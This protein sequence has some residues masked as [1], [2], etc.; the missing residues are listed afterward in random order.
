METS[1]VRRDVGKSV[2]DVVQ[3]DEE[4][5][6]SPDARRSRPNCL[7]VRHGWTKAR[8]KA[9]AA[10]KARNM[11]GGLSLMPT[12]TAAIAATPQIARNIKVR[13]RSWGVA[14][15]CSMIT[16][17]S[18]RRSRA[19]ATD[20]HYIRIESIFGSDS[21]RRIM[22]PALLGGDIR[23]YGA[24]AKEYNIDGETWSKADDLWKTR[25]AAQRG[26]N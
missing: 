20:M 4:N 11:P 15:A 18:V 24:R 17:P 6:P 8:T 12:R 16:S 21:M 26:G 13:V 3:Y 10:V 1:D 25:R 19:S 23:P 22:H 5:K 9:A 7:G 14:K 2:E